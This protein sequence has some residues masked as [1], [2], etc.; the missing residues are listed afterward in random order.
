MQTHSTTVEIDYEQH[1]KRLVE[2]PSAYMSKYFSDLR[3]EVN[4]LFALKSNREGSSLSGSGSEKK[5]HVNRVWLE[6]TA[7]IDWLEKECIKNINSKKTELLNETVVA[8][9]SLA[10]SSTQI[11]YKELFEKI[12]KII[13]VNKTIVFLKYYY[14][15]LNT[16][17]GAKLVIVRDACLTEEGVC[18]LKGNLK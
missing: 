5:Q 11:E 1:L 10:R 4:V 18:Y 14:D 17:A 12:R 6:M 7:K 16:E 3:N 8:A 9:L 13:F 15:F 2:S